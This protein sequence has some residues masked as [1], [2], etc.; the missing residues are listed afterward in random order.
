MRSIFAGDE[1]DGFSDVWGQSLNFLVLFVFGMIAYSEVGSLPWTAWLYGS[2]SLTAV[3]LV[4][5]GLSL[6][7]AGTRPAST[8]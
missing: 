5:V 3:R 6:I 1:M 7:G 4:A 2:M 8:S